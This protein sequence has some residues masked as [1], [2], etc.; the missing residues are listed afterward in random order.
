MIPRHAILLLPSVFI[1]FSMVLHPAYAHTFSNYE[2]AAFLAKLTEVKVE[3]DQ[4]SNHAGNQA[5]IDYCQ[6]LLKTYWTPN[7][8]KELSERNPQLAAEIT[9]DINATISDARAGNSYKAGSDFFD[10]AG[11]LEQAGIVRVDPTPYHD[12]TVQATAIAMV[13]RQSLERYGD[14]VGSP[15]LGSDTSNPGPAAGGMTSPGTAVITNQYAYDN[16]REL[17]DEALNMFGQMI[18][19]DPNPPYGDKIAAA[20]NKY[21]AD[22]GSKAD[23]STLLS[24]VYGGAYPNFVSGYGVDLQS[25]PEFPFPS[26]VVLA[27]VSA[28][29]LLTRTVAKKP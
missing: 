28:I 11:S 8:T 23:T 29:I 17:A 4:I 13:L 16:S 27:L 24:D 2:S 21:V 15:G 1:A 9:S 10:I 14:A 18:T 3:T 22:L 7:D 6:A 12:A 26:A 20:M 25:V 19:H 5:A